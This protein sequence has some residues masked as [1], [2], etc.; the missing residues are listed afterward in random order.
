MYVD[1]SWTNDDTDNEAYVDQHC[2]KDDADNKTYED[3]Y[4]KMMMLTTSRMMT[5]TDQNQDFDS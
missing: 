2:T 1:Q 5:N 4:R 3:Q